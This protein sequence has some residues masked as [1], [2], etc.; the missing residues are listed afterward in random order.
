MEKIDM[1]YKRRTCGSHF[2]NIL[3][4]ENHSSSF[5]KKCSDVC[6]PSKEPIND[7]N[8]PPVA[9][10][11]VRTLLNLIIGLCVVCKVNQVAINNNQLVPR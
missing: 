5:N 9:T 2:R 3:L 10:F 6:G 1:D 7:T 4:S 8:N 11:L